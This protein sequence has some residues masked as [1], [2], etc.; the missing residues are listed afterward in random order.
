MVQA[1]LVLVDSKSTKAVYDMEESVI[2]AERILAE[3]LS[4]RVLLPC[5]CFLLTLSFVWPQLSLVK[6][7][8]K[9]RKLAS[10]LLIVVTTITAFTFF[11]PMAADRFEAYWVASRRNALR[12]AAESVDVKRREVVALVWV[13][14][15]VR[16]LPPPIRIDLRDFLSKAAGQAQPDIILDRGA[17]QLA[18]TAIRIIETVNRD[19]NDVVQRVR[20]WSEHKSETMPTMSGARF[21][22]REVRRLTKAREEAEAAAIEAMKA[23]IGGIIPHEIDALLRPFVKALAGALI[24]YSLTGLFADGVSDHK[25][26]VAMVEGGNSPQSLGQQWKWTFEVPG[27]DVSSGGVA[28][29]ATSAG[30]RFADAARGGSL[31]VFSAYGGLRSGPG[32]TYHPGRFGTGRVGGGTRLH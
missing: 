32:T 6:R 12:E 27:E 5:V 2:A 28:G 11:A 23:V 8:A 14:R 9:I 3:A 4:V 17:E 13:D 29:S 1:I 10:V 25:S 19:K 24:K 20:E 22:T 26:A 21:V 16:R 7:F 18:S 15:S 31:R 30:T